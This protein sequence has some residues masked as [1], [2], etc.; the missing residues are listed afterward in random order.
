MNTCGKCGT[1]FG[2]GTYHGCPTAGE[3]VFVNPN[4]FNHTVTYEYLKDPRYLEMIKALASQY[5]A[6]PLAEIIKDLL[7]GRGAT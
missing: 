7:A 2:Q 5:P 4:S 3:R 6:I 1:T